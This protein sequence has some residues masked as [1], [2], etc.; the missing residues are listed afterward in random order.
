MTH[1]IMIRWLAVLCLAVLGY[2]P[3]GLAQD[4]QPFR[5]LTFATEG[6][7]RLGATRGDGTA[8]I[9]DIH[10]AVRY[11]MQEQPEETDRLLYIPADMK[12]LIEAGSESIAQV[13]RVYETTTRLQSSGHMPQAAR[14]LVEQ[15]GR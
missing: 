2:S 6:N 1:R 12:T 4:S 15:Q 13:R 5:L 11:L 3:P 10:N 14:Q 7:P 9:V 8:D